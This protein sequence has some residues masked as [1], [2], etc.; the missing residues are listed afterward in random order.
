MY[1]Y[2]VAEI[3]LLT[4]QAQTFDIIT[5]SEKCYLK[6]PHMEST[7]LWVILY[8]AIQSLLSMFHF[9]PHVL[10][11]FLASVHLCTRSA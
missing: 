1:V 2:T 9:H 8:I 3:T 6:M 11:I 7:C 10:I 5:T 4:V